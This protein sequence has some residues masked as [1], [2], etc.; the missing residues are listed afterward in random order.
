MVKI[1]GIKGL[2]GSGKDTIG[3]Y[4]EREHGYEKLAFAKPLK[5]IVSIVSGWGMD[6]VS[7][8]VEELRHL[9]DTIVHR[10]FNMTCREML[11]KIGTELFRNM[12]DKNIWVK[13]CRNKI[14][15]SKS[16][17]IVITDVRFQNEVNMILSLGGEIWK[18]YR[19]D[20]DEC[21]CGVEHESEFDF[22]TGGE[23]VINNNTSLDNLYLQ[24]E[25]KLKCL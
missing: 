19:S 3:D 22:Y 21:G 23:T 12:F 16:E 14:V 24:V 7:G 20:T 13:I 8:E 5:E 11:Q 17:N 18:V 15:E 25:E 1:I 2:A 6:Y 4:L 10:E 9:R